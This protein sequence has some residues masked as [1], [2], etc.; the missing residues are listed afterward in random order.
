MDYWNRY[1]EEVIEFM[2]NL[3]LFKLKLWLHVQLTNLVRYGIGPATNATLDDIH[4]VHSSKH[5]IVVNKRY[6]V[7]IN[8]NDPKVKVA[9]ARR[10]TIVKSSGN[11][12]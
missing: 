8:C 3:A 12:F 1:A 11:E 5:F 9:H 7:L 10:K 2:A 6:D 4:V